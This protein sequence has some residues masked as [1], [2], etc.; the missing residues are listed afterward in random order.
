MIVYVIDEQCLCRDRPPGRSVKEIDLD[1]QFPCIDHHEMN[2]IPPLRWNFVLDR[3]G[4]RSLHSPNKIND[5]FSK[6]RNML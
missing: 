2:K 5:H 6:E 3:R 1:G 4:R